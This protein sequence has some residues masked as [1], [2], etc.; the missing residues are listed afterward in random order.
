MAKNWEESQGISKERP[1][2]P[3]R[4]VMRYVTPQ[5]IWYNINFAYFVISPFIMF[6]VSHA[7]YV[8]NNKLV[9][10]VIAQDHP[11][12]PCSSQQTRRRKGRNV[13]PP[14]SIW[15]S[16]SPTPAYFDRFPTNPSIVR[17]EK[18]KMF[19]VRENSTT[20]ENNGK[21]IY[22]SIYLTT[23]RIYL[24]RTKEPKK[25]ATRSFEES[26]RKIL[27]SEEP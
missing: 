17:K 20:Y 21:E 14:P 22:L 27:E 26:R 9:P 3:P 13:P 19:L 23:E 7:A 2:K 4:E 25:T 6:C 5:N 24:S 15:P 16:E 12:P 11:G 8:C 1:A 18:K 10:V